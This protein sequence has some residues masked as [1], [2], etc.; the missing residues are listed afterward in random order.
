MLQHFFSALPQVLQVCAVCFM[1]F[2]RFVFFSTLGA[3]SDDSVTKLP[4]YTGDGEDNTDFQ[5]A[6]GSRGELSQL[7]IGGRGLPF[8]EMRFKRDSLPLTGISG[9]SSLLLL[10]LL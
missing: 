7:G 4:Y 6:P 1:I 9:I 5:P 2:F 8:I 3:L 10:C